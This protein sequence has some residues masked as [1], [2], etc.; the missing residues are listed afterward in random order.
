MP[1]HLWMEERGRWLKHVLHVEKGVRH[2]RVMWHR[3]DNALHIAIQGACDTIRR[4]SAFRTWPE[5]ILAGC[6]LPGTGNHLPE[7][8][9]EASGK[10]RE[11]AIGIL[12]P[13]RGE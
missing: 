3:A 5:Q 8:R 10:A 7:L 2:G 11:G 9:L 12:L 4:L 13:L 1:C 6:H